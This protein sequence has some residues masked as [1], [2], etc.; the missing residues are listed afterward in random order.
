MSIN[1]GSE[2]EHGVARDAGSW[3]RDRRSRRG[4]FDRALL[5]CVD[6]GLAAVIFVVPLVM[7]G[8]QAAGQLMLVALALS[9]AFCWCV[10]QAVSSHAVWIRS[11]IELLLLGALG[12]VVLQLVALP[13]AVVE[14]LSPHVYDALP[15]WSPEPDAPSPLGAWTTLSLAPA[16]TRDGLVLLLAFALLLLTTLQRV[17]HVSDVERLIRWT[18][19]SAS[20]M[21]GFGLVQYFMSNG[22]FFWVYEHPFSNTH[23]A[24]RGAFANPNHFAHF[25]ALGIGPLIW[26]AQAQHQ[27]SYRGR[28]ARQDLFGGSHGGYGATAGLPILALGV[29]TFGVLMSLSRGGTMAVFV[30]ALVSM[31]VLYRGS[32][33]GIR[34][35]AVLAA[36]GLFVTAGLCVYGYEFVASELDDF[37]SLEDL[38]K[39]QGRRNLWAAG[40]AGLSDHP[41]AGTGIGTHAEIYPIYLERPQLPP[42]KEYT[43]AESGYVQ[44]A[45]ETG[46]PGLLIALAAV[47]LCGYWCVACLRRGVSTRV[48]LCVAA[49]AASLAVSVVHSVADFV[50]YVP[51]CMVVVVV[52]AACAC[53]LWQLTRQGT[54]APA[55]SLAVPRVVWLAAAA[56]LVP[57]GFC[58]VQSRLAAVRSEPCWHRYLRLTDEFP[59]LEGDSRYNAL[60]G[61]AREL[62]DAVDARP[63]FARAHVKLAAV[64]LELFEYPDD[65]GVTP[66]GVR[67]VRDA[68]LAAGF[69]SRAALD[70]W[71]AQAFGQRAKHLQAAWQHARRALML[72]P[73]Q[74][75][76]YLYLADLSFLEGPQSPGKAAYVQQALSVRPFDGAVLFEVGKEEALAGNFD[77]AFAH[78]RAAFRSGAEQ[79]IA[80]FEHLVGQVPVELF[81]DGSQTERQV[82]EFFLDQ[83]QPDLPALERLTRHYRRYKRPEGIR[84]LLE[85]YAEACKNQLQLTEGPSASQTWARAADAYRELGN[86][87]E[88]LG[89]LRKAV[90][91]DSSNFDARLALGKCLRELKEFDEAERHLTWCLRRKPQDKELRALVETVIEQRLREPSRHDVQELQTT[92]AA[93]R[94]V[95]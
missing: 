95:Y 65:S 49:I 34:S 70:Q 11:P 57:V 74:G 76:G 46:V 19:F 4:Q 87:A 32:L 94:Q 23:G 69:D 36:I 25:L 21:A 40:I 7:G 50:W 30:A 47:G 85:R 72:C 86:L 3:M 91:C 59:K 1:A 42:D 26:W 61:M 54:G 62:S 51:G 80:L 9:I 53:R 27:K 89:C 31:L 58:M 82:L 43:H 16:A 39:G 75:E 45:L 2:T 12:L 10:R 14:L 93:V 73:L 38:D 44:V 55:S 81:P 29:C 66:L 33:I 18:A 60:L 90:R 83:F 5:G 67:H 68:A 78:W 52:L 22:K 56:C 63:D 13:P 8:R 79:Q 37:S 88:S 28:P 41:L 77:E 64:H 48:L 71:L 17:R 15:L 84:L 92:A 35:L 6:A 24:A 20:L